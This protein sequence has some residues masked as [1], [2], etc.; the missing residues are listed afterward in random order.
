[1]CSIARAVNFAW[2]ATARTYRLASPTTPSR[3]QFV[4]TCGVEIRSDQCHQFSVTP[5]EVWTALARVDAYRSWWP[6]LR[7]F[8]ADVL[9][10]GTTWSALV[11]PPVPYRL[12][13]DL[14][15]LEVEPP[16]LVT[17]TVTGDLIGSARLEISPTPTGSELRLVSHLAPANSVLRAVARLAPPVAHFGHQWV[18]DTGLRQFRQGALG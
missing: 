6:W 14:H 10:A 18:L 13:F 11:Q 15:L 4:G 17:A 7:H 16:Y 1:M 3:Q 9:E 8:E 5:A 12:R 2:L